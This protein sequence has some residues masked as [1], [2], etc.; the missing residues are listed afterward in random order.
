MKGFNAL[1]LIFGPLLLLLGLPVLIWVELPYQQW[2]LLAYS[3]FLFVIFLLWTMRIQKLWRNAERLVIQT[4]QEKVHEEDFEGAPSIFRTF[5]EEV[6]LFYL[7]I[8]EAVKLIEKI[9]EQDGENS[10]MVYLKAEDQL[11]K[12]ILD[13]RKK[14][15]HYRLEEQQRNWGL[16][17]MAEF[18]EL[19]RS[20]ESD[21]KEFG[22]KIIS[23]LVKYLNASQ[24]SLYIKHQ[25]AEGEYLELTAAFAFNR[26]KYFQKKIYTGEGLMG[27]C[28]QEKDSIYLTDVPQDY[29]TIRSGLGEALPTNIVIMPLIV[30]EEMEGAIEL[31]SFHVLKD[32]EMKFLRELASNVAASLANNRVAERTRKLLQESQDL[33]EELKYREE[34]MRQNMEELS[35]TQEEMQR[36]QLELDGV[37]R[38]I[39]HTLLTAEIS[40]KGY[41][42]KMNESFRN[43][44]GIKEADIDQWNIERLFPSSLAYNKAWESLAQGQS[45]SAEQEL[46]VGKQS[47]WLQTNYSPLRSAS[48]SMMKILLFAQDI[49]KRRMEEKELEKLSLV[50]DNTDNAV[51]IAGPDG[52]IEFVNK[53]FSKM[54]GYELE[55]VKGLKPGNF[56]QGPETN[57]ET[58]KRISQKLKQGE[59]IYEEILNYDKN[60]E[61]YWVSLAINPVRNQ[62][63]KIYK[64]ISVQA[65][66]TETKKSAL[67]FKYKMEAIS[68]SNAII[69]FDIQGNIVHANENFLHMMGYE[70]DEIKGQHH[71]IFVNSDDIDSEEY[72]KFWER[73]SSGES[74][75]GN[76]Q[77][78][79]KNG[80]MIHL[81]GVYN[82]IFDINGKP[83]KVVKFA[84]DV[85]AEYRLK[86]E[87]QKQEAELKSHMAAINKT[88]AC[89]EF[90]L[91][92]K[93]KEANDIYLGITG[94]NKEDLVGKYYF[95][96]L[97]SYE[98][99]KPQNQLMWAS[100]KE[101]QFF[102]GEYKQ[103]DKTGHELW[104]NGTFNPIFNEKGRPYKIMLFAQFTTKEKEKQNEL[105]G[106]ISAFKNFLPMLEFSQEGIFK[107]ANELF[108]QTF[109]YKRL[110]LR[111]KSWQEIVVSNDKFKDILS[112]LG[113]EEH[114]KK[115][116]Q[117]IAADGTSSTCICGISPTHNLENQINKV[118]IV[119]LEQKE[120]KVLTSN[121]AT[122][123]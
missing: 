39:N 85:T 117:L 38:A 73:L 68:R 25:D 55:E 106:T 53:G 66:I 36:K 62:E 72:R 30:N 63:G 12:A 96:L 120:N 76:F 41:L 19:L 21:M 18:A 89:L 102:S 77:R 34:Q 79:T 22:Y 90:D 81:K 65:N 48:G 122:N 115:E 88:I 84:L 24:A 2:V 119:L 86:Q 60:G 14:M 54:T 42:L 91:D 7:K 28:L 51:V 101:G 5:F 97:P 3:L 67:D 99:E 111:Q 11:G 114:I 121:L 43:L 104:L 103:I 94:Y 33:A 8:K 92:G 87:T 116:L 107:S 57:R 10:A 20:Q 15:G 109:G 27:Q 31:A 80:E 78:I 13:V 64:Y 70:L 45:Y 4:L 74:F 59:P 82:P 6:H 46:Q 113:Q 105:S 47:I 118:V 93:L 56:L 100:L 75:Q 61:T 35:T 16:Q 23:K 1:F 69:E 37:V 95:D 52:L 123:K 83:I 58:V 26:R 71:Q 44:L 98:R 112:E 50:A 29:I 9:D 17:G 110:D 108:F 32:F 40:P 49:T